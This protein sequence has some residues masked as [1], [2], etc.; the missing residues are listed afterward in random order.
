MMNT[1]RTITIAQ[2]LDHYRKGADYRELLQQSLDQCR[3]MPRPVWIS[4]STQAQLEQEFSRLHQLTLQSADRDDLVKRYPLFGVPFAAKDN[5]DVAG[6]PTTAA[7]PAFERDA[8]DDAS[9]V[10]RLRAAGAVCIGKTNLDQFATGLVGTRSPYGRPANVFST[11]HISGGSSSGSAVAVASY[12]VAFSL[13]TDTA[14]SGRI[15]AAF[16]QLVGLKPTPG[17]VST[18]GVLPA[19][20]TLDCVSVFAHTVADAQHV[21]SLIEGEDEQDA[22]SSTVIGPANLPQTGLRIAVPCA[23]TLLIGDAYHAP[24]ETA[25]AQLRTQ[26]HTV[27]EF[28]FSLLYEVASLLYEGPWVSERYLVI[29]D[30]IRTQSEK[31]DETVRKV[32][33]HAESFN[34]VDGFKAQYRLKTLAKRAGK[35]WQ[36]FDLLIVPTAP[37]HPTFEEVDADPV[38]VNTEMGRYTNFVNLLGW[39]ALAL[40]AGVT[41]EGLPFGITCI[42]QHAHDVAL[43]HFGLAW[44]QAA[45]TSHATI[46]RSEKLAAIKYPRVPRTIPMLRIGLPCADERPSPLADVLPTLNARLLKR[47]VPASDEQTIAF[48]GTPVAA[49]RIAERF[50]VWE[51]PGSRFIEFSA[52]LKAPLEIRQLQLSDELNLSL[53]VYPTPAN[54]H[55]QGTPI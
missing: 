15:P 10:A 51:F 54:D 53:V 47:N 2:Y 30:L 8:I 52:C 36:D 49:P 4:L 50:D 42:G 38:S 48:S 17:R 6:Y 1:N 39:S 9:V 41:A 46:R 28:D 23:S 40:P 32:I 31:L 19:C 14:G 55:H 7:C 13:G 43:T 18:T 25:L 22:Y 37:R 26:G 29:E 33:S 5:I 16:N 27:T 34:A 20:R 11:G 35:I 44:E 45:S 12:G 3:A 24:W 21:L